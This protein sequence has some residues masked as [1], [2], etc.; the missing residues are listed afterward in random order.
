[1]EEI[2]EIITCKAGDYKGQHIFKITIDL[3][4]NGADNAL[5]KKRMPT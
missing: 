4:K 5:P 2:N 3:N 1:M